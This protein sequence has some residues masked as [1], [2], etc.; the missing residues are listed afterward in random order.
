MLKPDSFAVFVVGEIRDKDGFYRNFVGDT[1]NAFIS[2]GM[3]YY[4]EAILFTSINTASLRVTKQFEPYRK[5]GKVH[6]NI[7]VFYKGKTD[8]I[9]P[10]NME[11]N[12]FTPLEELKQEKRIRKRVLVG[13]KL[14]ENQMDTVMPD[15]DI[16]CDICKFKSKD[17]EQYEWHLTRRYHQEVAEQ[18]GM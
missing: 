6:Q 16:I 8:R 1:I 10:M 12:K 3:K 9:T 5:F 7:L 17:K 15:T 14:E 11:N 4:N 18:N 13:R 2:S